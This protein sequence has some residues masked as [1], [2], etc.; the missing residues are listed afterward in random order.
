MAGPYGETWVYE[1]IVG[2]LPGVTLSD[3][4]A[5]AVQFLAFE[6]LVVALAAVYGL[7]N[8]LL[9]GTVAVAVAAV[10][11]AFM[12][13]LGARLRD[14]D[15]PGPYRRL[16]FGSSVEVV[17]GVLAYVALVTYLFVYDP[18][19][20]GSLLVDLLGQEPPVFAVSLLLLVLWDVCYR[21][22]TG[23][24]A[25]VVALW[26]TFRYEV[27]PQTAR[28][29]RAADRRTAAF[30][31][32]QSAL[33]PFLLDHPLLAGAVA[34]HVLATVAVAGLSARKLRS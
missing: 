17:L 32:L 15:V 27:D 12:L 2:A 13:D 26:R 23:W 7:W 34:G 30:G 5:V 8:A 6:A 16:L 19:T 22:G 20:D 9:P 29:L 28:V 33:L 21:I 31:A 10:G 1:S 4:A 24:W 3:H 18:R 14:A 11:S 25:A